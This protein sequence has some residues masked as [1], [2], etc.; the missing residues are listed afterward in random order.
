MKLA[1][2]TALFCSIVTTSTITCNTA[3][4]RSIQTQ[5][6]EVLRN[7]EINGVKEARFVALLNMDFTKRTIAVSIVNDICGQYA[8]LP[9]GTARCLAMAM[10]VEI[11]NVPME[12]VRNDGCG[13]FI[14]EGRKNDMPRDG[15]Y[16]EV[17]F[18]DNSARRCEN[19]MENVIESL[20]V[21]DAK[22][23]APRPRVETSYHITK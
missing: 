5:R 6:Y 23:I 14:Y 17:S 16:Q 9:P 20:L 22:V 2:A 3:E 8:D 18:T 21:I 11:L 7:V 12:S 10:P 1:L 13:S 15:L 19:V 4:A